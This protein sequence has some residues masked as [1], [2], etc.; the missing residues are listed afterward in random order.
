MNCPKGPQSVGSGWAPQ[1][2]SSE[3]CLK[4]YAERLR[5]SVMH[6]LTGLGRAG[7]SARL[8]IVAA[9]TVENSHP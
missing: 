1:S 4:D 2:L 6:W 7:N 3:S 9:L 8:F 5:A